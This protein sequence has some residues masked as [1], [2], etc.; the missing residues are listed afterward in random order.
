MGFRVQG[1]WG[2]GK[3]DAGEVSCMGFRHKASWAAEKMMLHL[4]FKQAW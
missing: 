4:R 3:D 2:F 1:V